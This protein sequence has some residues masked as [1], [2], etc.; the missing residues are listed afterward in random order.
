MLLAR[1]FAPPPAVLLLLLAI[2]VHIV[3]VFSVFDI[4]FK[5]PIVHG[6]VPA[7][8][9]FKKAPAKRLVFVVQ[10]GMR[11]DKFF[12]HTPTGP[13]APFLYEKLKSGKAAFGIQHTRMPTESRPCHVAMFAGVYE[14]PAA[15]LSAWKENPVLVDSV[16]N[17][18]KSGFLFGDYDVAAMFR[19]LKHLHLTT[20]HSDFVKFSEHAIKYDNWVFD[21]VLELL[22]N[23]GEHESRLREDKTM[24]FLHLMGPDTAGHAQDPQSWQYLETVT[25]VDKRLHELQEVLRKFYKDDDTVFIVTA[26]HGMTDKSS[27]GSGE[28]ETTRTPVVVFGAGVQP[29]APSGTIITDGVTTVEYEENMVKQKWKLDPKLRKDF[30]Q[31]DMASLISAFLGMPVP[32]NS[33]GQLPLQ[34]LPET[35]PNL[36]AHA[37]FANARTVHEHVRVKT[38]L[39]KKRRIFFSEYPRFDLTD[40]ELRDIEQLIKSRKFNDAIEKSYDVM[41]RGVAALDYLQK[42]DWFMLMATVTIGYI[43]WIAF[44]LLFT[45]RVFF[46]RAAVSPLAV[47]QSIRYFGISLAICMCYLFMQDAPASYYLYVFTMLAC[48]CAA[49]SHNEFLKMAVAGSKTASASTFRSSALVVGF[50]VFVMECVC[51]GFYPT[52]RWIFSVLLATVSIWTQVQRFSTPMPSR[53]VN[54]WT[55]MCIANGYFTLLSPKHGRDFRLVYSGG[56]AAAIVG[57]LAFYFNGSRQLVGLQSI[58]KTTWM[59]LVAVLASTYLV[60]SIESDFAVGLPLSRGKQTLAWALFCGSLVSWAF[61]RR[62]P[63]FRLFAIFLS[64][65]SL[66]VLFAINY[67]VH[68]FVAYAIL[69]YIWS[70]VE[71]SVRSTDGVITSRVSLVSD[72]RTAGIFVLFLFLAFFG[73]GNIASIASFEISSLFRFTT[74]YDAF[75]MFSLLLVKMALPP[76]FL[77][78]SVAYMSVVKTISLDTVILLSSVVIDV[79]CITFFFL[80]RDT[81]SWADIG[82]SLSYVIIMNTMAVLVG[83]LYSLGRPL[84]LRVANVDT[85]DEKT[86][87]H[88]SAED[89]DAKRVEV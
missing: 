89:L 45:Y 59:Q 44:V 42:Y 39:K 5:T 81:G 64:T 53:V 40:R 13:A 71:S 55:F 58:T 51:Y 4:Y 80:V 87:T 9:T 46:L 24:F 17:H 78:A 32:L 37:A 52:G 31:A 62:S 67:E 18:V 75:F 73:T 47:S 35:D 26:D 60:W 15:I 27:H 65:A 68:F 28:P 8:P 70:A 1:S 84:F 77:T 41:D 48:A 2:P 23:P 50:V 57:F 63:Q 49:Y 11:A 43:S 69:L 22:R 19:E 79:G 33:V 66:F 25:N 21:H 76:L 30:R 72:L 7:E 29:V 61:E 54:A 14:D 3:Y 36:R 38:E 82:N 86:R 20:F 88:Q 85:A 6:M 83:L 34:Y 74:V 16:W 12:E 10:D 56:V